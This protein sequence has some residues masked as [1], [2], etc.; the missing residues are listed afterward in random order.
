MQNESAITKRGRVLED[1]FFHRVDQ[2]LMAELRAK[3][4]AEADKQELQANCGFQD[5]S[6]LDELVDLGIGSESIVGLSLVPLVQVAWADGKVDEAERQAVLRAAEENDCP[7]GSAGFQLL[8][9]WLDTPLTAELVQA[10]KDYVNDLR[11]RMS[12]ESF[13]TL[14]SDI[15]SR[16]GQVASAAGGILGMGKISAQEQAAL[17]E[18]RD[19]FEGR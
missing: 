13:A 6:I 16:A 17:A 12:S 2:K 10:W 5:P 15:R 1:E 14:G 4:Q 3:M 11:E 9:H 7:A 18:I 19:T 8:E